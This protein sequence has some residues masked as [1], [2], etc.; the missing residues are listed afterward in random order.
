MKPEDVT[1]LVQECCEEED[2]DGGIPYESRQ[3]K[4]MPYFGVN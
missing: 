3:N 1:V 4:N 2:E